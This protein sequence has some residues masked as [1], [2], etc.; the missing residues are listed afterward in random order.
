MPVQFTCPG[1][2]QTQAPKAGLL[3]NSE[4]IYFSYAT[5]LNRQPDMGGFNSACKALE[6]GVSRAQ[7]VESFATSPEFKNILASPANKA[8]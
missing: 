3:S 1:E 5:V 4:F 7:L 6:S 8:K 2:S